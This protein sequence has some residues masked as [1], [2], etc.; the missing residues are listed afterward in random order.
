MAASVVVATASFCSVVALLAHSAVLEGPPDRVSEPD[1]EKRLLPGSEVDGG[2]CDPTIRGHCKKGAWVDD[3]I[4]DCS[5]PLQTA[6]SCSARGRPGGYLSWV[7]EPDTNG[8]CKPVSGKVIR[9]GDPGTNTR[10]VCS[11]YKI[12]PNK[13][14]CQ[15]W[16]E[17]TPGED[18][19]AFC[20]AYYLG[21][22]STVHHWACCNNCKDTSP[23]TCD[24]V[25]YHGGS[26]EEYCGRCGANIAN[27]QGQQK[28]Y[29]N[30]GNCD[31][32]SACR[33]RC[34]SNLIQ[35]LP[36]FCWLWIDCFYG[37]CKKAAPQPRGRRSIAVSPVKVASLKFCGDGYCSASETPATCPGDCCYQMN[38]FICSRDPSAGPGPPPSCCQ[39]KTCCLDE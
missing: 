31:I 27:N 14:V 11:D 1:R 17:E 8:I 30:C 10:C 21:G 38:P 7:V 35:T 29:F 15:Y 9:C 6:T 33:D 25:T 37:C 23:N 13:C 3:G 16:T 26:S 5:S 32:Q 24:G 36:G 19:P 18:Q 12:T 22:V 4:A 39:T 34:N 2:R 28:Y 20:N